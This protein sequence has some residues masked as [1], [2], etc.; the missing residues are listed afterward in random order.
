[1]DLFDTASF[2]DIEGTLLQA[3]KMELFM[4]IATPQSAVTIARIRAF[5][6]SNY[7]H[8]SHA[9]HVRDIAKEIP[10]G[11]MMNLCEDYRSI[12]GEATPA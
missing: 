2:Y 10:G 1:V 9:S 3:Q 12:K 6:R 7:R 11:A 4:K 5:S 8:P